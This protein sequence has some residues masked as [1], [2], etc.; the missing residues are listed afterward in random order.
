MLDLSRAQGLRL[1]LFAGADIHDSMVV[2]AQMNHWP[3]LGIEL[4][5]IIEL[6]GRVFTVANFGLKKAVRRP[7]IKDKRW[8]LISKNN[9]A[10]RSR[11]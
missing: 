11:V 8:W 4:W 3:P 2:N 6:A 5:R 10:N 7:L 9:H 1:L